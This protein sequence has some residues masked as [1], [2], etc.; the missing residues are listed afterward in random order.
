MSTNLETKR[1]NWGN[2]IEF[3]ML[4]VAVSFW[5]QKEGINKI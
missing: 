1:D 3:S 5:I 2:D 4:S